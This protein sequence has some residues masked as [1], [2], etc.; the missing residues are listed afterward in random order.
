MMNLSESDSELLWSSVLNHDYT[1]YQQINNK[2]LPKKWKN[3]IPIK[4]YVANSKIQIQSPV[5]AQD[6]PT[7]GAF[8]RTWVPELN[9]RAIIQGIDADVLYNT[10]LLDIWEKLHHLDDF[11]YVVVAPC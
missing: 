11:L 8:L 1:S 3:R 10:P 9:C 2:V 7:L 4:I 6:C 5:S